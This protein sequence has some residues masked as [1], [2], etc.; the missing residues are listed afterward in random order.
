[1]KEKGFYEEY[2][3]L[4]GSLTKARQLAKSELLR[5]ESL[6]TITIEIETNHKYLNTHFEELRE[7]S[8]P[9]QPIQQK[10]DRAD[11]MVKMYIEHCPK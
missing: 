6:E 3:K 5:K 1:M 2:G 9:D 10:M 11:A 7:L 8:P 4:K